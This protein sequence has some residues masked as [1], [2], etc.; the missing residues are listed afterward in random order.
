MSIKSCPAC[1]PLQQAMSLQDSCDDWKKGWEVQGTTFIHR[2][3][4]IS[5]SSFNVSDSMETGQKCWMFIKGGSKFKYEFV[6]LLAQ[7][8]IQVLTREAGHCLLA[9]IQRVCGPITNDIQ[10][11]PAEPIEWQT[12]YSH[13]TFNL[14]CVNV[15][16]SFRVQL[17]HISLWLYYLFG[18]QLQLSMDA[19]VSE[20]T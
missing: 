13:L 20:C 10:F 18:I 14:P 9:D 6:H 16:Y 12:S 8:H 3:C 7:F 1:L 5:H 19:L 4:G 17:Y 15:Y 2:S 11:T